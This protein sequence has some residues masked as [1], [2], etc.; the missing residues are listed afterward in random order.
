MNELIARISYSAL[1]L[2][3]ALCG[4]EAV[5]AYVARALGDPTPEAYGRCTLNPSKHI[6]PIGT[7][8]LPLGLLLSGI[9]LLVGWAKPVPIDYRNFSNL[10]SAVLKIAFAGPLANLLMCL[11]WMVLAYLTRTIAGVLPPDA[12]K[13]LILM[14]MAGISINFVL[15]IFLLLPIPPLPGAQLLINVLPPKVAV[16]F[17]KL[18][19]YSFLIIVVLAMSGILNKVFMYPLSWLMYFVQTFILG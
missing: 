1:P 7:I 9:P 16:D 8:F 17:A 18:Q 4:Q 5:R 3:F 6:D 19:N 12:L 14:S 13:F 11:M 10:R 2:I 15:M